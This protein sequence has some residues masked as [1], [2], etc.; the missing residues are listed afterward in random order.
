MSACAVYTPSNKYDPDN[1]RRIRDLMIKR[2]FVTPEEREIIDLEVDYRR[3]GIVIGESIIEDL[4]SNK[5][6]KPVKAN[7]SVSREQMLNS[8]IDQ[9]LHGDSS[10]GK[11]PLKLP[12]NQPLE[13]IR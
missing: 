1:E 4:I 6:T 7:P 9:Q 12:P 11:G 2:D 8:I 5:N 13:P 3:N 10:V